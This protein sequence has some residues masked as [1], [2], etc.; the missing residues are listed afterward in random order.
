M[1]RLNDHS[2]L[3]PQPARRAFRLS[4]AAPVFRVC[5]LDQAS[6]W[7]EEKLGFRVTRITDADGRFAIAAM[8]DARIVLLPFDPVMPSGSRFGQRFNSPRIHI[9]VQG[10][11]QYFD[12]IHET[13]RVLR[14]AIDADASATMLVEDCD[15]NILLFCEETEPVDPA[16]P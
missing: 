1:I 2:F 11:E 5:D 8:D 4:A 6:R 15:G 12:R 16:G 9:F 10:I 3:P 14:P 7:Y 13:V